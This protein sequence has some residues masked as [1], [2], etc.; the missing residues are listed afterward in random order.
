MSDAVGHAVPQTDLTEMTA[1]PQ[2]D[3]LHVIGDVPDGMR[4]RCVRCQTVL[5]APRRDAAVT[6]VALAAAALVLMIVAISFPFLNIAASGLSS[7]ASVLDAAMSFALASGRMAPLSV[8]V[9]ALII[10][11]PVARLAGLIYALGP[12]AVGNKA[13]PYAAFVFRLSMRLRPWA[14]AEIFIIGVAVAL[15]KV[16]S[17]ATVG[18]GPAFWAFVGLVI[19]VAAKD[20]VLCERSMWRALEQAR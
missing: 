16:A 19:L 8:I 20:M 15:V 5:L 1:C 10:V 11:L 3:W 7:S 4:A 17:L 12:L 13:R 6:I 2:C 9:A 18:F 14:M